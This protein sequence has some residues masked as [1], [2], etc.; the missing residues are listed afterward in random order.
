MKEMG[1]IVGGIGLLIFA[2]LAL[3][4]ATGVV[5]IAEGISKSS[6][7]LISTLQGNSAGYVV[8]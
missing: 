8:G 7:G 1:T 3:T 6:T 2:Y 4:H 5:S